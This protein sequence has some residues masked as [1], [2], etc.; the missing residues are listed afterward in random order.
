MIAKTLE[1]L[2]FVVCVE[3]SV[4][5]LG[6]LSE[7]KSENF[8]ELLSVLFTFWFQATKQKKSESFPLYKFSNRM[9][10]LSL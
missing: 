3:E 7:S 2:Y 4:L 6:K 1:I 9:K 8:Q 5:I 10:Q